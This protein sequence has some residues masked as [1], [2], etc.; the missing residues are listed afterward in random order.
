MRH[1]DMAVEAWSLMQDCMRKANWGAPPADRW[2]DQYKKLG[3]PPTDRMA[4]WM[5]TEA[6]GRLTTERLEDM[7]HKRG[8][9]F[10]REC[11]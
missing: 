5:I 4:S 8:E 9:A 10:T 6:G 7:T 1:P 2:N 3:K 11:F